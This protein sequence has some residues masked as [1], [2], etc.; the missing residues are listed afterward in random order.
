MFSNLISFWHPVISSELWCILEST[1]HR[2]CG[3]SVVCQNIHPWVPYI[4]LTSFWP[5][6]TSND[7][8][9]QHCIAY[10]AQEYQM[11]IN[12]KNYPCMHFPD[13]TPFW[14]PVISND[15]WGQRSIA[16]VSQIYHKSI[17]DKNYIHG[18]IF[19]L[20][21]LFWHPMTI[22][23]LLIWVFMQKV[24]LLSATI[25]TWSSNNQ[26]YIQTQATFK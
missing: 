6:V 13:F 15:A 20:W 26:A 12:A 22:T 2:L 11:S 21:P 14:H 8:W 18:L 24:V 3:L 10:V 16:Y 9:G 4:I 19:H 17:Y 5:Q 25:N 7:C 23:M 1:W